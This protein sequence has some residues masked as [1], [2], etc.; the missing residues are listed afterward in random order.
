MLSGAHCTF[1]GL[2]ESSRCRVDSPCTDLFLSNEGLSQSA[3]LKPSESLNPPSRTLCPGYFDEVAANRVNELCPVEIFSRS[4]HTRDPATM[5]MTGVLRRRCSH[6]MCHCKFVI[7]RHGT[8]KMLMQIASNPVSP[9]VYHVRVKAFT[10][11]TVPAVRRAL[12]E[13]CRGSIL[14]DL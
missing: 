6:F 8:V 10:C 5:G 11:P 7:R 9:L 12:I 13:P 14:T 4:A 1:Q 3:E 2:V